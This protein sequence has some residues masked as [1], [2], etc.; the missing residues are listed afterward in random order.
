MKPSPPSEVLTSSAGSITD[1]RTGQDREGPGSEIAAL[2][3]TRHAGSDADIDSLLRMETL[4][5]REQLA[6]LGDPPGPIVGRG[7]AGNWTHVFNEQNGLLYEPSERRFGYL[8][9]APSFAS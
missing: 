5:Y 7:Q 3:R 2:S 1:G 9:S 4:R 6:D 8:Q